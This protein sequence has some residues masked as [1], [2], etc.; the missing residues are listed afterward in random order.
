MTIKSFGDNNMR[1]AFDIEPL[2]EIIDEL[3]EKLRAN[4]IVRLQKGQCS[5]DVGFVWSDLLTNL[6][7]VSDHCSNIAGCMIESA[8]NHLNLHE[9]MRNI[10]KKSSYFKEKSEFYNNKYS[11]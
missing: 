3:K 5:V 8:T 7:R 6:E 1:V 4:H 9:S 2:E 11:I 10:K